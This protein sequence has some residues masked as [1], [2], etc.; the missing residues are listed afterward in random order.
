M[1]NGENG[2]LVE[3]SVEKVRKSWLYWALFQLA[4]HSRTLSMAWPQ[5]GLQEPSW[6]G[7]PNSSLTSLSLHRVF[8]KASPNGKVSGGLHS[9]SSLSPDSCGPVEETASLGKGTATWGRTSHLFPSEG[10]TALS[11]G[12]SIQ[13]GGAPSGNF[14]SGLQGAQ[15]LVGKQWLLVET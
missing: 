15:I 13:Q 9:V 4:H 11:S 14:L 7:C 8:K 5:G 6:A 10:N 12:V 1:V 3:L 2:G